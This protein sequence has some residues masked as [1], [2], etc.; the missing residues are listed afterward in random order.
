[1]PRFVAGDDR[2]Q[3]ILLP[4]QLDDHGARINPVRRG[5]RALPISLFPPP[6][7]L[8]VAKTVAAVYRKPQ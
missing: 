4:V 6:A 5:P 3:I 7:H 2:G 1:M 8:A